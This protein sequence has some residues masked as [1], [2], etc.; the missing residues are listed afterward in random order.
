MDWRDW[1]TTSKSSQNGF[2]SPSHLVLASL[3]DF[4]TILRLLLLIGIGSL[5]LGRWLRLL[6]FLVTIAFLLLVLVRLVLTL[7]LVRLL[8]L[9]LLAIAVATVELLLA[10]GLLKKT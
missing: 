3:A 5:L 7:F 1:S 4:P 2:V 8:V 6:V 9:G 10:C